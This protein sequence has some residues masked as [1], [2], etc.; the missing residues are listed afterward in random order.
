MMTAPDPLAGKYE[1]LYVLYNP[2][3]DK[4]STCPD[5]HE[6]LHIYVWRLNRDG[7][8]TALVD[9]QSNQRQHDIAIDLIMDS[10]K[11]PN[12]HRII[13]PH[14]KGVMQSGAWQSLARRGLGDSFRSSIL[15]THGYTSRDDLID[16]V[17]L[18][19]G[20]AVLSVDT[21]NHTY[22]CTMAASLGVPFNGPLDIINIYWKLNR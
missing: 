21:R 11:D 19:H 18:Y 20:P 3:D 16:L 10:L 5:I 14:I 8:Y 22:P 12:L 9:T 15:N 4:F 6:S 17:E 2:E 13:S 1:L 7:T